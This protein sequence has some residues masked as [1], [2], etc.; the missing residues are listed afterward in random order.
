AAAYGDTLSSVTTTSSTTNPYETTPNHVPSF[1]T[2][3]L[4]TH[5]GFAGCLQGSAT[6][7]TTEIIPCDTNRPA[8]G[9]NKTVSSS[10]SSITSS[11]AA[12]AA[13][14]H[15]DNRL[16]VKPLGTSDPRTFTSTNEQTTY[17]AIYNCGGYHT[18]LIQNGNVINHGY[19]PVT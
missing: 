2:A 4:D 15:Y 9:P 3:W 10:S 14:R 13:P 19:T 12:A 1:V 18:S 8:I 7:G 6:L 16:L 17:T 5:P 11:V